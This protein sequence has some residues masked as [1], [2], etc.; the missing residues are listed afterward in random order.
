[1]LSNSTNSQVQIAQATFLSDILSAFAMAMRRPHVNRD[2]PVTPASKTRRRNFS[3]KLIDGVSAAPVRRAGRATPAQPSP[4]NGAAL[5][6]RL[7]QG[8][9]A[10]ADR[11]RRITAAWSKLIDEE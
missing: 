9:Q 5:R 10:R 11:N 8:A 4:T 7:A 3:R 1:M 6:R 2:D